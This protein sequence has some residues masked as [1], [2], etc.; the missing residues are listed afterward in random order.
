MALNIEIYAYVHCSTSRACIQ[1]KFVRKICLDL[2]GK[3]VLKTISLKQMSARANTAAICR[4]H[5]ANRERSSRSHFDPRTDGPSGH[6]CIILRL[7]IPQLRIQPS[8]GQ[9]GFV[10]APFCNP[11]VIKNHDVVA[12]TAAA[13]PVGDIDAGLALCHFIEAGVDF[14]F[15]QRV[16]G[17]CRLIQNHRAPSLYR[18]R[19]IASFWASPPEISTP[20]PVSL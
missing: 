1:E 19:A 20:S 13:H 7:R 15:R 17:G 12:E 2:S 11:S 10:A 3:F 18:A 6:S 5:H 9:Q 16:Q 14:R 4:A 8:R